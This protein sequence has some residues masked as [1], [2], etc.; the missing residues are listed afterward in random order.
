[1]GIKTYTAVM[2]SQS[3][4]TADD[5]L[6]E[7]Q[8]PA[9]CSITILRAWVGPA[10]GTDPL[11]EVQE[12]EIYTNDVVS[13]GGTNIVEQPL[14]DSEASKVVATRN[15]TT[16]GA[17]PFVVY[18]DAFHLQNG[19]LYLPVPEERITLVSGSADPGDNIGIL[20]PVAPDAAITVSAGITWSEIS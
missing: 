4:S 2:E 9:N 10:E 6:I 14:S 17:T 20:F 13:T 8:L 5:P 12:V 19:W 3:I 11:A 16:L 7:L 15:E 18:R 1:M